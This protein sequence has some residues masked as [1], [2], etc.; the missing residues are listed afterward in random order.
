M[1]V[2][3]HADS[4][5]DRSITGASVYVLSAHGASN[6]AAR[7]LA[8][9]EN[10]ADLMGG[11]LEDKGELRPVLL[12]EAQIQLIGVSASAAELVVSALARVGE[13]RRAQVQQAGF[14]VL[15]SP[16]FP[17]MLIETA[18]ISNP[19][20]ER[21]LRS[22]DQQAR[23]AEAIASGMRSYFVQNPPDGTRFKQERRTLASAATDGATGATPP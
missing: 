12:D 6:E 18:Y 22:P 15:K 3:I 19:A 4:I 2:S 14:V 7:V 9:R 13:V 8:E 21:R 23:L 20:E 11:V 16:E 1:F 10:A 17:S 5:A